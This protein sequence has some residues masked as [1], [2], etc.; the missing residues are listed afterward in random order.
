MDNEEDNIDNKE[1]SLSNSSKEDE[2][3]NISLNNNLEYN[4]NEEKE[5]KLTQ[6][7]YL[8]LFMTAISTCHSGIISE[9]EY[10]KDKKLV[11]QASSPDEIAI[12]NFA[13][14]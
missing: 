8:D 13:R 2:D 12:L 1:N 10:E 3:E 14:K 7:K 4:I 11:Y 9:K 6:E 5:E